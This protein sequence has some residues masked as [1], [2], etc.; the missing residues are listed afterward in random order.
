MFKLSIANQNQIE[1]SDSLSTKRIIKHHV[2]IPTGTRLISPPSRNQPSPIL[3]LNTKVIRSSTLPKNVRLYRSIPVRIKS[4][5]LTIPISKNQEEISLKNFPKQTH[6]Q[7]KLTHERKRKKQQAQILADKYAETDTWFQLRQSLSEL[8][9]LATTQDILIDPT[10]SFFNCDGQ[11]FTALKQIINEEDKK[12]AML[13]SESIE[14]ITR[15]IENHENR[16]SHC[17]C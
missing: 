9:R 12:V 11:S 7:R 8:K 3:D 2:H 13:K 6:E 15:Q 4:T 17:S 14:K 1:R 16:F 10:T 5:S